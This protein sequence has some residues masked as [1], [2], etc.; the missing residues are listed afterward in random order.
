MAKQLVALG[1]GLVALVTTNVA[2]Q[3]AKTSTPPTPKGGKAIPADAPIYGR[4][5]TWFGIGMGAGSTS[6]H[7]Q[8]CDNSEIGTRG[9]SGYLRAGTTINGRLLVGAELNGWMRSAEAGN[10]RVVTLTGNGYWYP[11]PR[12]GY[13][14]KGGFGVSRYKQWTTPDQN[15]Q[16][17]TEGLATG[18]LTGHVGMGYEVRVNPKMSFAPFFNL[19]G[20]ARGTLSTEANDGT[21]FERNKL[22]NKANVLFLQLGM[23]VTW[24]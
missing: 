9:T 10:Q 4:Q 24:H 5:G 6:I 17:R 22:P 15:N 18:G 3:S 1:V 12:H 7:C 20:T 13:Y 16:E 8:I 23:G 2:A 21:R 14:F 11:N 19:I